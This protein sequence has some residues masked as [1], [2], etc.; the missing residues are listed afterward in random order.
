MTYEELFTF[1]TLSPFV[2]IHILIQALI[3]YHQPTPFT[4]HTPHKPPQ[5]PPTPTVSICLLPPPPPQL[6]HTISD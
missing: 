5:Q 6:P 1:K 3:F 2:R 4:I